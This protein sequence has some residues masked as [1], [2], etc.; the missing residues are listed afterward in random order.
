VYQ[1]IVV[2]IWFVLC[3]AVYTPTI[4][5][6]S[7]L[8]EQDMAALSRNSSQCIALWPA[9][10]LANS[11]SLSLS[12]SVPPDSLSVSLSLATERVCSHEYNYTTVYTNTHLK[13]YTHTHTSNS[14]HIHTPQTMYTNTHLKLYTHTHTHLKLWE[15]IIN[16]YKLAKH[17]DLNGIPAQRMVQP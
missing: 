1:I 8:H 17:I 11:L 2:F 3:I 13:L 10:V 16:S 12:L 14:I 6:N 9:V 15:N 4:T 7:C 5:M